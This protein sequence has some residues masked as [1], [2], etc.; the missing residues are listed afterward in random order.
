MLDEYKKIF[1]EGVRD[2]TSFG[3]PLILTIFAM[4]ILGINLILVK[5]I[6]G[7]I[8]IE[9][10][11]SL[12][13][14][15]YY[16]SRPIKK[17]YKNIIEKINAGSFPSIHTARSSFVFLSLF[18]ITP[19]YLAKSLFFMIILLVAGTRIILKK[20]YLIDVLFGLIIGIIFSIIWRI[21]II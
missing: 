19:S 16:K 20:H 12:I 8:I 9:F 3:N 15:F 1:I 6:L 11:C 7:L 10:I 5:I 18:L 14:V 2:F 21:F 13:K 17:D 4:F